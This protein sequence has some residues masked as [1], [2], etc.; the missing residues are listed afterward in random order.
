[1]T[2]KVLNDMAVK[3][4]ISYTQNNQFETTYLSTYQ[5]NGFKPKEIGEQLDEEVC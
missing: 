5:V 2:E 3:A 4:N 1:M